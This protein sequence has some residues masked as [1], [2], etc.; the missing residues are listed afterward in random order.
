MSDGYYAELLREGQRGRVD[1][2][3]HYLEQWL[4]FEAVRRGLGIDDTDSLVDLGCGTGQLLFYLGEERS[5][6]YLGVDQNREAIDRARSAANRGSFVSDD[7]GA[8]RVDE[9]G[10]FDYAVA[11]GTLVDGVADRPDWSRR[12]L[13][14]S[15]IARLESLARRGWALVVLDEEYLEADSLLRL[16]PCLQGASRDE[17]EQIL[18][19]RAIPATVISQ[20]LPTD[21]FVFRHRHKRD[22][23]SLDSV[24]GDKPHEHVVRRAAE[25]L[26]P[27]AAEIAWFWQVAGRTERARQALEKVAPGDRRKK[28]IAR[29]LLHG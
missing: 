6:L 20:V 3:R 28:I 27:D 8:A 7:W 13:L 5:G 25:Q 9:A 21:L 14:D 26:Q 23:E 19:R 15:L 22:E 12:G 2:W 16:E 24:R 11:I 17:L 4:R 1:G 18:E 29:R 10:P